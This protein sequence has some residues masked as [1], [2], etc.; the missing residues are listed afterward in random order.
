[1]LV[2]AEAEALALPATEV[3]F[4]QVVKAVMELHGMEPHTQVVAGAAETFLVAVVERPWVKV[5]P[6]VEVVLDPV[7]H[8][9]AVPI[10]V[11]EVPVMPMVDLVL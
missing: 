3:D 11:V 8:L 2:E 10:P 4:T 1:M 5:E 9:Q 7:V 6:A